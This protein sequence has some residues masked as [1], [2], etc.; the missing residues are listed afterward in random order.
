[1]RELLCWGD[2]CR[3]SGVACY[4]MR[5][6]LKLTLAF[7]GALTTGCNQ[8][9]PVLSNDAIAELKA[10]L[11]GMTDDCLARVS[12]GGIRA[13]PD[14]TAQCFKMGP[15][16]RYRGLLNIDLEESRFCPNPAQSCSYDTPG[17]YIWLSFPRDYEGVQPVH[18][19]GLYAI[20]FLGRQ[21]MEKGSYGHF[22]MA[23]H[24]VIVERVNALNLVSTRT[25]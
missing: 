9:T 22:G 13:F 5:F 18:H 21:T 8:A 10:K 25:P 15:A 23:Q 1:M 7:V 12:A 19:D 4:S 2:C 24:E 20:D 3:R 6:R 17:S 16:Q 14:D 11:P